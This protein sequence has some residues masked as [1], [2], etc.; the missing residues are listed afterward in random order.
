MHR[1]R[2]DLLLFFSFLFQEFLDEDT[3]RCYYKTYLA[4]GGLTRMAVKEL[5]CILAHV[6]TNGVFQKKIFY[7]FYIKKLIVKAVGNSF[8]K[9]REKK[10]TDTLLFYFLRTFL[11]LYSFAFL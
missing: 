8:T 11:C 10:E 4:A 6:L 2:K 1:I 9:L 3:T 5:V 7:R